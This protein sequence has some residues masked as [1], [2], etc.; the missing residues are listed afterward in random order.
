MKK[1]ILI[2]FVVESEKRNQS[3]N[4]YIGKL[5]EKRYDFSQNDVTIRYVNMGGKCNYKK[6]SVISQ[7]KK[8]VNIDRKIE[9]HVIYCFDTDKIDSN[10]DEKTRF[11]EELK[12]C[13]NNNYSLIWFNY[14]IEYVLLG[15][16]VEKN[17]KKNLQI[18]SYV[19]MFWDNC[20]SFSK[21]KSQGKR[22][23]I[24]S[25]NVFRS[26]SKCRKWRWLF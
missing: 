26:C 11:E 21:C 16:D 6:S 19:I 2:I 17:K 20:I 4:R 14:N 7:I 10:Y 8:I 5:L 18:C 1:P 13:V 15:C 23:S 12:Y 24:N 25:K 3:D 9:N 22:T